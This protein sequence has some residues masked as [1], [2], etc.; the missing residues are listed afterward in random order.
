MA[1]LLAGQRVGDIAE[2]HGIPRPTV[3]CWKKALKESGAFALNEDQPEKRIASL[4]GE[5]LIKVF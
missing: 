4:I 5:Y 1:A 3:S 2:K